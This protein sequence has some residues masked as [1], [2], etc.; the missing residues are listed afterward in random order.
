MSS[1]TRHDALGP[2]LTSRFQHT[3]THVATYSILGNMQSGSTMT[4]AMTT[5]T[6]VRCA[7][8]ESAPSAKA[9]KGWIWSPM[10][11]R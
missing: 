8:K 6:T 9:I 10:M 2:A 1:R 11:F 4:T 7:K 3:H 5:M